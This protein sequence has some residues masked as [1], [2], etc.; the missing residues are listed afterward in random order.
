MYTVQKNILLLCPLSFSYS[1]I[2]RR[3]TFKVKNAQVFRYNL[4]C[5]VSIKY[6]VGFDT[7]NLAKKALYEQQCNYNIVCKGIYSV[8]VCVCV[9]ART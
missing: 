7:F 4:N 5:N 6:S 9:R 8:C 2:K 1:H 3:E